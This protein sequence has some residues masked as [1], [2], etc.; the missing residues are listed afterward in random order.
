GIGKWLK[1]SMLLKIREE[2]PQVKIVTTGNANSNAPMLSIN[3][4]L[5]FKVH[6][7]S[8]NAQI[9]IEQLAEFLSL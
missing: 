4:R 6:K 2:Y 3:N 9:T 7:E 5:G 8:I 1:A